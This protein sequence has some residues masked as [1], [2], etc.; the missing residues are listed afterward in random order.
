MSTLVHG[1]PNATAA[2]ATAAASQYNG[3]SVC[4][5]LCVVNVAFVDVSYFTRGVTTPVPVA[6]ADK[7]NMCAFSCFVYG[8]D[9]H[10][11]YVCGCVYAGVCVCVVW[12]A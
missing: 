3:V 12:G 4:V 8:S 5:F 2:V 10:A 6:L 7:T 9:E 11:V 1:V